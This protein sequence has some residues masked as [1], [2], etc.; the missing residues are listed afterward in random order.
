[1]ACSFATHT[2][3]Y[4]HAHKVN[5]IFKKETLNILSRIILKHNLYN[6]RKYFFAIIESALNL[7]CDKL[8]AYELTFGHQDATA[9][10]DDIYSYSRYL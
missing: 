1:M 9:L 7:K 2:Y 3:T 6:N 4:T 10:S 5:L 8:R